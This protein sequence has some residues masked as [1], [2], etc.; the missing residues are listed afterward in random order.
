MGADHRKLSV[1]ELDA[2]EGAALPERTAMST[3]MLPTPVGADPRV[4][5]GGAEIVSGAAP[6]AHNQAIPETD[7]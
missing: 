7:G 3:L 2:L 1:E 6:D 5:V 4:L